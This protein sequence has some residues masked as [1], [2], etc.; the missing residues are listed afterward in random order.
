MAGL[1]EYMRGLVEGGPT[2]SGH[3]T[4]AV[5]VEAPVNGIDGPTSAS[6]PGSSGRS[7]ARGVH[8]ILLCQAESADA[9]RDFVEPAAT[10]IRRPASIPPC[11]RRASG[12]RRARGRAAR[13][14]ARHRHARARLGA[15]RRAG[16]GASTESISPRC[17]PWPLNPHGE[18]LLGVKIESPEGVANCEEICAV[19]GL[20]FAELGRAIS[21]SRSATP[22]AAP[23][24]TRRRW[25]GARRASS[26]PAAN[27]A[28]LPGRR[29]AGQDRRQARRGRARDR[30]PQRR[31][32]QVGRGAPAPD[33][34]GVSGI[35]YRGAESIDTW[36]RL[37]PAV[38][39]GGEGPTIH[40]FTCRSKV[41]DA[42]PPP[43][44]TRKP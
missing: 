8:G 18:L 38:T 9:V 6:T 15:D 20:G 13:W 29:D 14:P 3:R 23:I 30:R 26:P 11:R 44:M 25:R 32:G 17:D 33:D 5:I 24:P 22:A 42:R 35:V 12:W 10:R 39:A 28:R 2:R 4:P 19:P 7:S 43:S 37:I 21:A 41:V 36:R 40:V 34:A 31:H 27:N 1:A 16:L